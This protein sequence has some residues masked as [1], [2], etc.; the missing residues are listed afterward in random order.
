MRFTMCSIVESTHLVVVSSTAE[1]GSEA[2][3]RTLEVA[4]TSAPR[5]VVVA[6]GMR[7][8]DDDVRQS[9]RTCGA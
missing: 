9:M 1:E 6:A 7:S 8:A 3:T 5:R 4:A 2:A